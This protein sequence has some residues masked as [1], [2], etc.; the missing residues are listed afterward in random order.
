MCTSC[1]VINFYETDFYLIMAS[2]KLPYLDW[3]YS[4]LVDS[5]KAFKA[6]MELYFVDNNIT[7]AAKKAVKFKIASVDKGMR[8][9]LSNGL[10]QTDLC[11]PSDLWKLFES[12]LDTS[13][14]INFR[15]HRLEFAT[16]HQLLDEAI[17]TYVS[18][19]RKKALKCEF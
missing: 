18:R 2:S 14:K 17:T 6:R 12:Q 10:S 7:D 1:C 19:L 15:V 16:M 3:Q 8:R 5:Y 11:D 13:L 4:P 9:I